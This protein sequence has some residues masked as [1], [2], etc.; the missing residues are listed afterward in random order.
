MMPSLTTLLLLRQGLKKSVRW[1]RQR[2]HRVYEYPPEPRPSSAPSG[3]RAWGHQAH[4]DYLSM[5]GGWRVGC[6]TGRGRGESF[7]KIKGSLPIF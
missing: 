4:L 6:S 5:Q 1:K 2:H 7:P 3:R